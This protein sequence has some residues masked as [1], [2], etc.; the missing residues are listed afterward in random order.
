MV[1][2]RFE[3]RTENYVYLKGIDIYGITLD[4]IPETIST[5][6]IEPWSIYKPDLNDIPNNP[7]NNNFYFRTNASNIESSYITSKYIDM[8]V[9]NVYDKGI[10][11]LFSYLPPNVVLVLRSG[12]NIGI[13]G[14]FSFK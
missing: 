4:D 8:K 14:S 2:K 13:R 12:C 5:N 9:D 6:S 3:I 11:L 1:E 7:Y 10:K